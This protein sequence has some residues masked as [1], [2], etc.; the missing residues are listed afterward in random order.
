MPAL[1]DTGE[2]WQNKVHEWGRGLGW[3]AAWGREGDWGRE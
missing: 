2:R 3:G 1:R